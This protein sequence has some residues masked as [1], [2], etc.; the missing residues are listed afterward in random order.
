MCKV[1]GDWWLSNGSGDKAQLHSHLRQLLELRGA[2]HILRALYG[3]ILWIVELGDWD[4]RWSI[5]A[6]ECLNSKKLR[7]VVAV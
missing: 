2:S 6:C 5:A 1:R 3:Q 7:F 4:E